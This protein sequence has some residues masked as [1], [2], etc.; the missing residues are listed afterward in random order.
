MFK[1]EQCYKRT[2][3][4]VKNID[5]FEQLPKETFKAKLSAVMGPDGP[6]RTCH[7]YLDSLRSAI[8]NS[9]RHSNKSEGEVIVA[10]CEDSSAKTLGGALLGWRYDAGDR[11]A[12][13][14][15][16]RHLY[17]VKMRGGQDVWV[18]SPPVNYTE[19]LYDE[20]EGLDKSGLEVWLS[21]D[22]EVYS[23]SDKKAM[24]DATQQALRWSMSCMCKLAGPDADTEAVVKRWFCAAGADDKEVKAVC[25]KLLSGFKKITSVLNGHKLVLS[26]EPVDRNG[27]GWKDYAFVYKS[28]RMSVI[29][30]QS[31]TLAAAKGGKMW[32]AA[33]TIVHELSHRELGTDDHRYGDDGGKLGPASGA[34]ALTEKQAI[35]N[36]D[37]WGYFAADLNGALQK[38][39]RK[40]VSGVA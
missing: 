16:L 30:I 28:E 10:G 1:F 27:G 34:G 21:Q 3:F 24:G 18:F 39:W 26:D 2:R 35:T 19:W 32:D 8:A 9:V 14:K 13:I 11:C 5:F 33:L 12:A 17:L 40:Y 31:A 7:T 36:A 37:N 38:G 29:Y 4:L 25:K 22:E 6:R 20:L 23:D 15:M